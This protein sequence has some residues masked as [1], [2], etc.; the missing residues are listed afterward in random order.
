MYYLVKADHNSMAVHLTRS[1][2]EGCLEV[3]YI[4]CSGWMLWN[5]IKGDGNFR[6]ECEED[7]AT[8]CEDGDSD[9]NW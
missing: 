1:D 8:D 7:E 3:L 5:G 6:S 9:S 4:Q 2:Y